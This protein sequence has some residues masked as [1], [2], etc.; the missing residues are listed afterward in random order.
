MKCLSLPHLLIQRIHLK[1]EDIDILDSICSGT[2]C[3][4]FKV[5]H[6]PSDVCMAAK[7]SQHVTVT[8]NHR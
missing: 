1:R 4:V 6:K 7:V 5:K 2:Y 3:E 8:D